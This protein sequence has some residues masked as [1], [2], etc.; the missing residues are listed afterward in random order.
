[1]LYGPL[2]PVGL[3]KPDGTRP[4]AVVQLRQD[5]AAGS[6]YNLVGFQTRLKWGDQ[7]RIIQMIPGLEN[8]EIVRYGVMHRNTFLK[9]PLVLNKNF[10]SKKRES[11]FFAGQISGVEGYVESA[12]SGLYAALNMV[13][14][15]EGKELLNL[16]PETIIGSMAQYIATANPNHFQPMNANFGLV[17]NRDKDRQVMV[18]RSIAH[19]QALIESLS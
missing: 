14:F 5:N 12:A 9:S 13:Q 6:L 16:S 17:A 3:E 18:D 8:V 4:Y 10:Q 2:K 7:K 15:L 1:M 11:L 19:I